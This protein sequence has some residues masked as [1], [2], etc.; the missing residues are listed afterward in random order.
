MALA[1]VGALRRQARRVNLPASPVGSRT[2]PV[3]AG[4]EPLPA[5]SY[6][7]VAGFKSIASHRPAR[8]ELRGLTLLA[9]ANSSGKS[10]LM[11]PIL[12][13]KQTLEASYD[14]GPLLLDGPHVQFTAIDQL[15]WRG[16][17]AAAPAGEISIEFGQL[18][19]VRPWIP[20]VSRRAMPPVRIHLAPRTE[21]TREY[22]LALS[23][24]E[25]F[26]QDQ[27]I[28]I[29]SDVSPA[30]ITAMLDAFYRGKFRDRFDPTQCKVTTSASRFEVWMSIDGNGAAATFSPFAPHRDWIRTLLH[31]PGLRGHR[32]RL[33]PTAHAGDPHH[34]TAPGPFTPYVAPLL[35]RWQST[36]DP[37]ARAALAHVTDA[38]R[39][40]GLTSAV[41][42]TRVNAAQ[43]TLKVGRLPGDTNDLVDLADVGF[44]VSQVLPVVVALAAAAP[45]QSVYIEQPEL[46]L[47]PRAQL[48]MGQLLVDA[49]HRGVKVVVETHSRMILRAIQTEVAR[50]R[51]EP[52]AIALHW[53]SR[54][55]ETGATR[56]DLAE[57]DEQGAF[58]EWPVDFADA[59]AEADDA[60]LDA[61]ME[62]TP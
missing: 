28:P 17:A 34:V 56:V 5:A 33:Y 19:D 51:I 31:L 52:E 29:R 3:S 44:G 37:A 10:A 46:H 4:S 57:L 26:L 22:E 9:G 25:V 23:R 21:E 59:E 40:M 2:V 11:Q 38:M 18:P 41:S 16:D 15:L 53:F 30:Q 12:L 62:R 45:G 50:R 14:P 36:D 55:P 54:D 7:R 49:T 27:W 8:L 13:L 60:W 61:V 43:I 32:D 24:V 48:V 42:A 35:A 58:G 6:L 47:H 1:E 20:P 39:R